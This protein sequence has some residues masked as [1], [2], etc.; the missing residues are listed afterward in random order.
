MREPVIDAHHHLWDPGR[1]EYP[2]MTDAVAPII[3][4]FGVEDLAPLLLGAGVDGTVVV[5]ARQDLAETRELLV[6]AAGTPFIVGV[7]GWVDLT[8]ED[9]GATIAALQA[10]PG[11]DRLVGI[12]HQVHDEPDP[13]WLSRAEVRRGLEA[14]EAARLAYDLLIRSR[15]VPAASAVVQDMP[16][17]RFVVDHLAKPPIRERSL[18][19][20]A[21]GLRGLAARPNVWAKLSGLV[22]EADWGRVAG[23]GPRTARG[24]RDGRVRPGPAAVRLGL[25]G[26]P[27]CGLLR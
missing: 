15:E 23:R 1:A 9:V 26:L 25:A 19:A 5:Q 7:V 14:V 18:T 17:L 13:D 2:W 27:A 16:N 24:R 11:G 4:P 10:G 12:R 3:R 6:I 8:A 21:T 22:T 20:W